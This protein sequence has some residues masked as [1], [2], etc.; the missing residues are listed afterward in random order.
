MSRVRALESPLAAWRSFRDIARATRSLAAAQA[1]QWTERCHHAET[2]LAWCEAVARHAAQPPASERPRVVLVL[3][4]DLGLC[5]PL[6]R[7]LAER[8][9]AEQLG[10]APTVLSVIVGARLAALA[11]LPEAIELQT[12]S[13]M[14][15]AERL[16]RAVER[17][18]DRLPDPHEVELTIVLAGAV[19][20][21]GHPRI[22]VRTQV[23][24]DIQLDATAHTWLARTETPLDHDP[25]LAE[26]ARL[27]ARHARL[28]A[29]LCRAITSE[30]EARWRTMGR[31]HESA[32]RRIA[33]QEQVLRKLRQEQITQEMLEARQGARAR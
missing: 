9:E 32:Q 12:P 4:S 14:A 15:A 26:S 31:A 27:L 23:S 19:E 3:G 6:N 24:P 16:A 30:N 28:V 2:H 18:I 5:G 25:E 10:A 21:D 33:E 20:G 1:L 13:S 29:A 8:C 22:D 11:P 17:L 7:L